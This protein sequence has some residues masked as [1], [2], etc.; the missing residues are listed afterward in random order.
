[1][2]TNINL[3][4]SRTI[5]TI[6]KLIR[7]NDIGFVFDNLENLVI[8]PIPYKE[9]NVDNKNYK[10]NKKYAL[11]ALTIAEQTIK[12]LTDELFLRST[13]FEYIRATNP[14]FCTNME[15]KISE[16]EYLKYKALL[17]ECIEVLVA[18]IYSGK[19][20]KRKSEKQ[21]LTRQFTIR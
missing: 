11:E 17:Q 1:M 4:K 13:T 12:K 3:M 10:I 18:I 9:E 2:N 21:L 6:K 16:T 15:S 5:S 7:F 19:C 8:M 20:N 14:D